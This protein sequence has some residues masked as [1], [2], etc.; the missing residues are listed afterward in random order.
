MAHQ[1]GRSRGALRFPQDGPTSASAWRSSWSPFE[2]SARRPVG[3]QGR[4]IGGFGLRQAA[5]PHRS[6]PIGPARLNGWRRECEAPPPGA[7][8][9][10]SPR[11]QGA[12]SCGTRTKRAASTCPPTGLSRGRP[13]A[14]KRLASSASSPMA[15]ASTSAYSPPPSSS[16]PCAPLAPLLPPPLP[17]PG[18]PLPPP[19]PPPPPPPLPPQPP[20]PPPPPPPPARAPAIGRSRAA[21]A[22]H[23][24]D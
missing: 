13:A 8:R 11:G 2:G 18:P 15:A 23:A 16:S 10:R 6:P 22:A 20:P 14:W 1:G 4:R 24:S 21:A 17:P 7:W 12:V 19:P 9:A 3:V 5:R